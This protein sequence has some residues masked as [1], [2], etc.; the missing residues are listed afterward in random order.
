MGDER[1]DEERFPL[2]LPVRWEGLSGNYPSRLSDLG[3]GGCYIE[4][5]AHVRPDIE[6]N[7][8]IQ[9]P[10]GFWMPLHGTIVYHQP[11][12]GFGVRFDRL[13]LMEKNLLARVLA[14]Y[15]KG[16]AT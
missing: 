12:L 11:S 8:E 4:T 14:E 16:R 15:G 1:R 7:F 10:T 2:P 5:M 9:L 13:T 3:L 6:I